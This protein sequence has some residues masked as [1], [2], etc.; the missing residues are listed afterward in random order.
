MYLNQ[1]SRNFSILPDRVLPAAAI[2]GFN[3]NNNNILEKMKLLSIS[4]IFTFSINVEN[5]NIRL[6]AN[7]QIV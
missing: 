3:N 7:Y 1:N 6:D 4:Q 5:L 2:N